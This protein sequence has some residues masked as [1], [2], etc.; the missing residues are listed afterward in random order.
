[1]AVIPMIPRSALAVTAVCGLA[2]TVKGQD[3][4]TYQQA[5]ADVA[6]SSGI[7]SPAF[8]VGIG[9]F[10]CFMKV[11]VGEPVRPGEVLAVL[12]RK[13]PDTQPTSPRAGRA[14]RQAMILADLMLCPD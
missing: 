11:G 1:M 10:Y 4:G 13:H 8:L 5:M 12:H 3:L 7:G 9:Q 2:S 14:Q 6:R